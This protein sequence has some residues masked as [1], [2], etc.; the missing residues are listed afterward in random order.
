MCGQVSLLN[1]PPVLPAGFE[2]DILVGLANKGFCIF[3]N[4]SKC[5]PQELIF[6]AIVTEFCRESDSGLRNIANA[7]F[8]RYL[9][10]LGFGLEVDFRESGL[11]SSFL[12]DFSRNLHISTRRSRI[13]PQIAILSSSRFGGQKFWILCRNFKKLCKIQQKSRI[14]H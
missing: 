3:I 6:E 14:I 8:V 10:N 4:L 11:M 12:T 2:L 9:K 1:F 7:T 13:W 5:C